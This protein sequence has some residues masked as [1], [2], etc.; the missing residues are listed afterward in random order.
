MDNVSP[1][2]LRNAHPLAAQ[3]LPLLPQRSAIL[4]IGSGRGRNTRAFRAAGHNVHVVADEDVSS[5]EAIPA[6]F[7]AAL[8]THGFLHGTPALIE[9]MLVS[10][11]RALKDDGLLFCTFASKRDAR[12]GHGTRVDDDTFAPE[13]GEEAG[14][15]HVYFDHA[16]VRKS[17]QRLFSIDLLQEE[18]VDRIVGSWAHG[19]RAR[20]SFHWFVRARLLR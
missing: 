5:F 4:E 10:T 11:A 3:L 20:N 6:S 2:E 1:D 15:P 14:V 19:D 9:R 7:D 8:S 17:L 12:F 16:D 18:C 13:T